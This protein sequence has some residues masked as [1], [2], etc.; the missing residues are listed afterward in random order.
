MIL[1]FLPEGAHA[2]LMNYLIGPHDATR[3]G[4]CAGYGSSVDMWARG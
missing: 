4:E 2:I 1:P 3:H